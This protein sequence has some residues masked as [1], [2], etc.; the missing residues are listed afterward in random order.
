LLQI[1]LP[2]SILVAILRFRLWDIDTLFNRALVHGSLTACVIGIYVLIV[3]GLATVF[4]TGGNLVV[5]LCATGV[6]AVI[7]GPLRR[8]LQ[9]GVNHLLYGQRDEPYAALSRLDRQLE[10]TL[11]PD[12]VLPT[13]VEAISDALRLP[14]VAI[15]IAAE[16]AE[17]SRAPVE[18]AIGAPVQV[19][20]RIPLLYGSETV[21]EMRLSPRAPGESFSAADQRLV[22][23]LA[24][25]AGVAAH[26]IR[27]TKDLQRTNADLQR[28]RVR[29]IS[30]REEERRRLRRDLHDGLGSSLTSL[31]FGMDAAANLLRTDP[32]AAGK[33][34][35]EMK[36]HTQA[37]IA[38]IRRLIYD[39]RPPILDELGLV[40]ALREHVSHRGLNGVQASIEA[41]ECMPSLPAAVELAAYRIT[42]EGLTNSVRHSGARRCT[43]KIALSAD[44]VCVEIADD[45]KG[46]SDDYRAG[47]GMTTMRERAT[48]LGGTVSIESGP[49]GGTMVYVRLPLEVA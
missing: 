17:N 7:F 18:A 41:P 48:E 34:L 44:T 36:A 16:G 39:L 12:A 32:Y 4:Q 22:T 47:V 31:T 15:T 23:D 19:P 28:A 29:L 49:N 40:E 11:L 24:R 1:L 38:D 21:G 33:L 45:G 26:A 42:L 9:Q 10:G 6:V 5:T 8:G 27:L 46:L 14:Y 3:G 37:A 43:I 25:H 35:Q 20:L 13:I 30:A 2:V